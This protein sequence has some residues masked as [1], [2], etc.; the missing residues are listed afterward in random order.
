VETVLHADSSFAS[1]SYLRVK[2]AHLE[3]KE[4][5]A[6]TLADVKVPPMLDW[7]GESTRAAAAAGKSCV[8][9]LSIAPLS[10]SLLASASP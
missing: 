1:V 6:T 8:L 3:D 9:R 5:G 10:C 7:L 2:R 4:A